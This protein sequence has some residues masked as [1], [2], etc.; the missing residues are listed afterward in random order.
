MVEIQ[1][2]NIPESAKFK[3]LREV[4]VQDIIIKPFKTCH[5]LAQ[6]QLPDGSYLSGQMPEHFQGRHFGTDLIRF[7]Q[8]QHHQ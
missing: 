2:D 5:K 3:G 8:R 4:I 7:I 6:Y 1:P